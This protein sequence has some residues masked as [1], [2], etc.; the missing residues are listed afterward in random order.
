MGQFFQFFAQD[1]AVGQPQRQSRP[2]FLVDDEQFQFP[3][4][5][6]MIPLF[7]FFEHVEMAFEFFFVGPGRAVDAL[8][9]RPFLVA[10][11]IG[12]GNAHQFEAVGRNLPRVFDVGAAA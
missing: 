6:A 1:V 4:Q 7:G 9:H 11:P 12:P 10:A 3:A 8:Q 5:L 2:N